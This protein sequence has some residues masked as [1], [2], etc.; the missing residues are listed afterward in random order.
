MAKIRSF[1]EL[2]RALEAFMTV[3]NRWLFRGHGSVAWKLAP[4]AGRIVWPQ[5]GGDLAFFDAWRRRAV[6][7][8]AMQPTTDLEWLAVAQ[9]HGLA[10]R[11]LDWT[12]NP[13]TAAFFAI[14]ED[15]A[16]DAV[17]HMLQPNAYVDDAKL[18]EL[19]GIAVYRPRV[20]AARITTQ[21]GLFT[22]H[23]PPDLEIPAFPAVGKT[24][25]LVIDGRRRARLL[26]ELDYFGVNRFALF[27]DL[28]G[29]SG[30]YNWYAK[31]GFSMS[32]KAALKRESR[33][34]NR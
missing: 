24:A 32:R 25:S 6:P 7:L 16:D 34:R 26:Q 13:L 33:P 1:H 14:E 3:G 5:D 17:I 2:A 20:I 23:S 30:Y 11:L 15:S 12:L 31:S 21:L 22:L 28:D 19:E 18:G 8:V 29:L 10:T 4:K 9:H 27:P